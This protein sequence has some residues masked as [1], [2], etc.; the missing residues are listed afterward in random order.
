MQSS[1]FWQ[2]D[3][4]GSQRGCPWWGMCY[5]WFF[6]KNA[7][8]IVYDIKNVRHA[9]SYQEFK[10]YVFKIMGGCDKQGFPMKQGV[11]TPGRVRL[12]LHRGNDILLLV[13]AAIWIILFC[14][15]TL[16]SLSQ[17]HLASVG[18]AGVM[19]SA[20]GSRFV[21]ALS[22]LIS[23][24]WTWLLLR[25]V[26]MIFQ[27]WLILRSLEWE[28]LREPQ[29]SASYS[30]FPRKMMS[31]SMSIRTAEPSQQNQVQFDITRL[32]TL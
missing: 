15:L 22:A 7:G 5:L 13:F 19:G 26:R 21:D 16:V 28:D 24:F 1:I 11:L 32:F 9:I 25:K 17:V 8:K 30:T 12:L 29:K 3:L 27:G 20:G 23:Q 18:M 14:I 2:E 31:A 6:C 10:G 4:S